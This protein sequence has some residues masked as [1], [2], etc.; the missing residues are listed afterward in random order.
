MKMDWAHDYFERGYAQRWSL[1]PPSAQTE[2]EADALWTHLRLSPGASLLDVG[3]G[4]GRHSVALAQRGADVIGV[5]FAWHLLARASQLARALAVAS[6]WVRGD[7]RCLPIRTGA[8]QA[9][10]L[11]D[12]FGFFEQEEENQAVLRELARVLVPG[13]RLAL[14]V[15]NGEPM[16]ADFRATEREVRGETTVDMQRILL[17]DPPRL[18]EDLTVEGPRGS[19][20]Y[21]RRQRI[22]RMAEVTAGI[23]AVGLAIVAVVA[24]VMGAPF[25]PATSPAIVV[26]A[27]RAP[28]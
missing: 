3:C 1:G 22:Y 6:R 19:G 9:T 10:T 20:R 16:L 11:F 13:G 15:V 12:A 24:D 18:I 26:I 14:K 7:M 27:E 28:T 21:Q 23:E 8:V 5:D 2:R 17:T 25:E 4:H